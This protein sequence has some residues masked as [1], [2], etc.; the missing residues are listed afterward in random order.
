MTTWLRKA[1]PRRRG[2]QSPRHVARQHGP[3]RPRHR[4]RGRGQ[5]VPIVARDGPRR[6]VRCCS[7]SRPSLPPSPWREARACAPRPSDSRRGRRRCGPRG[8]RGSRRRAVRPAGLRDGAHRLRRRSRRRSRRSSRSR[9]RGSR[10]GLP[11]SPLEGGAAHVERQIEAAAGPPRIR[12]L[13]RPGS[14]KS[15]SPP[16][17]SAFGKRSW[18]SRTRASGSSPSTMAQTPL[19]LVA[20]RIEPSEHSPTAKRI[21]VRRRRV[22]R[23]RHAEDWRGCV[24]PAAGSEARA[25]IASVTVSGLPSSSLSLPGPMGFGIGFGRHAALP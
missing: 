7:I 21:S 22:C 3:V 9:R 17:S 10:A 6:R 2:R 1:P 15:A 18:R 12:P 5:R 25:E 11:D 14:S 13:W 4:R 8:G 16:T 24:E 23:W 20:T 19:L